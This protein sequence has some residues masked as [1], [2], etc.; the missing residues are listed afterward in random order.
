MEAID[1]G[2]GRGRRT[3]RQRDKLRELKIPDTARLEAFKAWEPKHM[4]CRGCQTRAEQLE[5]VE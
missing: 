3:D 1:R 5:K 4:T 2:R